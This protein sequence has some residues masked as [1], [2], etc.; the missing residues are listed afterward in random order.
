MWKIWI[1]NLVIPTFSLEHKKEL[2]KDI[3][4]L[5]NNKTDQYDE[6]SLAIK[7]SAMHLY[8]EFLIINN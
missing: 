6:D 1:M 5:I 4:K 3:L 7:E 2:E 8:E